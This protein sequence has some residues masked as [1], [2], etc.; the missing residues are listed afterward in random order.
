MAVSRASDIG[1]N[2]ACPCGSGKKFKR[3]CGA[4]GRTLG[5]RERIVLLVLIG[6]VLAAIV[7]GVASFRGD[8]GGNAPQRVWSEEHGHWHTVP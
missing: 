1:R 2:Q 4:S 6:V 5:A 3:C 8:A 7:V